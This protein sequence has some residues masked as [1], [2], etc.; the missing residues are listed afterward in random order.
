MSD[1]AGLYRRFGVRLPP[2]G[3][4]WASTRCFAGGHRDRHPSARVHLRTGGFRCFACGARGGVL[5]AL[6]LLGVHDRDQARQLA[7]DHW[8]LDPPKRPKQPRPPTP[9]PEPAKQVEQVERVD[10]DN[11]DPGATVV[12]DRTWTYVDEHGTPVGRVRRL[13]LDDGQ[14][15][16]WQERPT[17][18]GWATGL[19]G[20]RLPLY[21]LPN[22]LDHAHRGEVVLVVEGEKA[23]DALER[24]GVFATTNAAGAG[25]WQ[26]EHTAALAGATVV[27]VCDCDQPGRQHAH[28]VAVDLVHAG[29]RTLMPYDPAPLRRDG[30]DIVDQLAEQADTIRATVGDTN[31]RV[32]LRGLLTRALRALTPATLDTL[33]RWHEHADYLTNPEHRTYIHCDRCGQERVHHVT[34]GIAYCRCGAHQQAPP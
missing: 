21:Q 11:L 8:I 4:G 25:K 27:P 5:D 9:P 3:D 19:D 26:P 2:L 22:V 32:R 14:K 1:V 16:I 30:Y 34:H 20:A 17:A 29:I 15:R 23:V 24:L 33:D 10:W 18:A 13:D 31:L 6:Q 28:Q 12:H 7:I